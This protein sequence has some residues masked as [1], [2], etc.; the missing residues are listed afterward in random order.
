MAA[1]STVDRASSVGC[2]RITYSL[3]N[4]PDKLI[5][6]SLSYSLFKFLFLLHYLYANK[7]FSWIHVNAYWESPSKWRTLPIDSSTLIFFFSALHLSPSLT[8]FFS[9]LN[10]LIS[11]LEWRWTKSG[12]VKNYKILISIKRRMKTNWKSGKSG[13]TLMVVCLLL[14]VDLTA[15]YRLHQS[16]FFVEIIKVANICQA[17]L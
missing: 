13:L 12:S 5:W 14:R 17:D 16:K 4:L 6:K 10:V 11:G 8:V 9:I 1:V 7:M 15:R 3:M 2:V